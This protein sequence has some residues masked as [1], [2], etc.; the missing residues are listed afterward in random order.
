LIIRHAAQGLAYAYNFSE[1]E[2]TND[3]FVA[4]VLDLSIAPTMIIDVDNPKP[5]ETMIPDYEFRNDDALSILTVTL[6]T[7]YM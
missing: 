1:S 5:S 4:E 2:V 3:I 7:S 6:G